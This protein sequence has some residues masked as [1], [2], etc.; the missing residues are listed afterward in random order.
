MINMAGEAFS[1]TQMMPS[2][3]PCRSTR[4]RK[5]KQVLFWVM[6]QTAQEKAELLALFVI[7]RISISI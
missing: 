3:L 4:L 6:L 5:R 2:I 1:E 7:S